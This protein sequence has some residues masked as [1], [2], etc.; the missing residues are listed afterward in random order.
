MALYNFHAPYTNSSTT[1]SI[2]VRLNQGQVRD[3][4]ENS[5][6]N[7][8]EI[9]GQRRQLVWGDMFEDFLSLPVGGHGCPLSQ[10]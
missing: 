5:A 1:D 6:R 9:P 8:D 3:V 10:L 7:I 4:L 2:P